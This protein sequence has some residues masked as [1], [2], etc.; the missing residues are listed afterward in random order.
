[1]KEVLERSQARN[2][3]L[4]FQELFTSTLFVGL[5]ALVV[6]SWSQPTHAETVTFTG[7]PTYWLGATLP[8]VDG[9]TVFLNHLARPEAVF[10]KDSEFPRVVE[11]SSAE[12]TFDPVNGGEVNGTLRLKVSGLFT[13]CKFTRKGPVTV[14]YIRELTG[15][16]D[17]DTKFISGTTVLK[18][19]L[20]TDPDSGDPTCPEPG[21]LSEQ[22]DISW[23]I[24]SFCYPSGLVDDK[25]LDPGAHEHQP[26]AGLVDC[27]SGNIIAIWG[28]P[29]LG[30]RKPGALA[31]VWNTQAAEC[32]VEVRDVE[33]WFEPSQG[34][35]QDDYAFA[36]MLTPLGPTRYR[37]DLDMVKGRPTRL[38]DIIGFHRPCK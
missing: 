24:R 31:A 25:L 21:P 4:R 16:Y 33:G 29:N 38:F 32:E 5:S 10:G 37:A 27:E 35:W 7:Y 30:D 22:Q 13:F 18:V 17:P 15:T 12:L 8:R 1:M 3:A 23:G 14:E 36:N 20:L 26:F 11:E 2:M 28:V 19:N 34:V 6:C 9:N